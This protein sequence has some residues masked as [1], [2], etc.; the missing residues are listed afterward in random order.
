LPEKNAERLIELLTHL[1]E[2]KDVTQVIK[3]LAP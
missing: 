1:E 2:V 3:L